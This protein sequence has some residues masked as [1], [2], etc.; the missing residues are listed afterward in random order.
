MD[1]EE[2]E[3]AKAEAEADALR[4]F[5][6]TCQAWGKQKGG[7]LRLAEKFLG[8]VEG[9]NGHDDPSV[10][11]PKLAVLLQYA[12]LKD[13]P[14]V[15]QTL[16]ESATVRTFD[17]DATARL[18][19]GCGSDGCTALHSACREGNAHVLHLLLRHGSMVKVAVLA[20]PQLATTGSSGCI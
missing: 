8:L 3:A 12:A 18:L 5:E 13:E 14:V 9:R 6:Q 4:Q 7:L 17:R 19:C 10:F 15:V 16:L 20:A 1:D 2:A 11:L